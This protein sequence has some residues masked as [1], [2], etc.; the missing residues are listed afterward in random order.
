MA[1]ET[2]KHSLALREVNKA[3]IDGLRAAVYY[4]D[5]ADQIPEEQWKS[6]I[7]SLYG[8]IA[9]SETVYGEALTRH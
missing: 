3:L 6:M 4:L 9:Q 8:L 7:Q 2:L 1:T 5:K